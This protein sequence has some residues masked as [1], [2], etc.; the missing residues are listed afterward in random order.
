MYIERR[1][2]IDPQEK[3]ARITRFRSDGSI[4]DAA[5]SFQLLAYDQEQLTAI[6][7][8]GSNILVIRHV[9]AEIGGAH[10]FEEVA[11]VPKVSFGQIEPSCKCPNCDVPLK[12]TITLA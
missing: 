6:L 3:R 12:A 2:A 10:P 8:M 7:E 5:R 1:I 9:P 4:E 11:E